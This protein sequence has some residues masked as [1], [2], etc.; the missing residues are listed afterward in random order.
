MSDLKPGAVVAGHKLLEKLGQGHFGEVWKAEID[1]RPCALKLFKAGLDAVRLRREGLAQQ[2]LGE[3]GGEDGR[4]FPKVGKVAV[5]ADPPHLRLEYVPGRTLEAAMAD[6]A[7]DA[8]RR[9]ALALRLAEAL[10]A[11]HP[12]GFVHGDLSPL[13]ILITAD[14]AVNLIDVG[15]GAVVDSPETDLRIST[16]AEETGEVYGVASPLYAAP[17]RFTS[18]FL[19]GCGKPAD[20]FSYGKVLYA[21][22]TGEPPYVVKP[23]SMRVPGLDRAWDEFIFRCLEERPERRY[24]DAPALL[25]GFRRLGV[26]ASSPDIEFLPEDEELLVIGDDGGSAAERIPGADGRVRKFCPRCGRSILVEAR[27]CRWCK[28]WVDGRAAAS[29]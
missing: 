22:L 2:A 14:D 5:D 23:V 10:A 21:L 7:L 29:R 18:K 11:V 1:G 26:D 4:H 27:K 19:A 24:A 9:R 8:G 16:S 20:V 6:A 3:L 13:N 12:H 15:F 25:D 28:S 17:E